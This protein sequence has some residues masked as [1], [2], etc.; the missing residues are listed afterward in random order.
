VH[1]DL[2]KGPNPLKRLRFAKNMHKDILE[3]I[4]SLTKLRTSRFR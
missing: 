4:T 1:L 2:R 3:Y